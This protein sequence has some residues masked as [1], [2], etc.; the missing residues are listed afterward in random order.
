LALAEISFRWQRFDE[1]AAVARIAGE[2]LTAVAFFHAD[3]IINLALAELMREHGL[4]TPLLLRPSL[5]AAL[6]RWGTSRCFIVRH[7]NGQALAYVYFEDEPGRR[8]AAKLLTKDEAKQLA[9]NIAKLPGLLRK[10]WYAERLIMAG[11][12]VGRWRRHNAA[13]NP[14]FSFA[15]RTGDRCSRVVALSLTGGI[16]TSS[17][18]LQLGDRDE[19][20]RIAAN[21]AKLPE[22][23]R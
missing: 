19:A 11:S 13:R 6:V 3:P 21:I 2:C 1:V 23:V 18:T 14:N 10:T 20:R 22:L 7:H 4:A 15:R 17:G 12:G 8:A 9:A 5:P 16:A